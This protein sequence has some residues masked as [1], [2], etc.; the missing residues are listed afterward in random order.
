MHHIPVIQD[1]AYDQFFNVIYYTF[2]LKTKKVIPEL[3]RIEG[4]IPICD[5]VFEKT[6]HCDVRRLSKTDHPKLV[7]AFFHGKV[8]MHDPEIEAWLKPIQAGTEKYRTEVLAT[9][10]LPLTHFRDKEGAFGNLIADVL[11]EKGK[12]DFSLVNSGGIRTSLDAG[13]ITYDGI[14]RALPFDNLLNV[15]KLNGKQLKLLYQ[16]ATAGSHGIIGFSGLRLTLIPYNREVEKTD[17]DHNGKLED[18][19]G[20]RLMKIETSD[21]KPILDKKMYTVATFDFLVNGGDDLH[22][23]MKQ[24]PE[25]NISR[26]NSGYCRD[27][28]VDYLKSAKVINTA[29]H[30]LVDPK[31]PRV[32]FTN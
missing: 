12:A 5:Q 27:L 30:P 22:W 25:K 1:E 17:L 3:T 9:S 24:I 28:L 6:D 21:G 10:D 13:P 2:D 26:A 19:E 31:N 4:L 11:R 29:E 7:P 14:F 20:K 15:V 16:I 8:V 18:W 23:F 32:I